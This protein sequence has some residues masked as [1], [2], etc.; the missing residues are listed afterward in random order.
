MKY[1]DQALRHP[2]Y[3]KRQAS[4]IA[5]RIAAL[6]NTRLKC[7][8]SSLREQITAEILGLYAVNELNLA[9]IA[10]EFKEPATIKLQLDEAEQIIR[11]AIEVIGPEQTRDKARKELAEY[12]LY[13]KG[14]YYSGQRD[15]RSSC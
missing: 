13:R 5:A 10:A 12:A 15:L 9:D 7:V 6:A 11:L 2:T 8:R 1:V 14:I 3:N 4:K